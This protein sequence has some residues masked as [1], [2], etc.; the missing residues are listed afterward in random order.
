MNE[1]TNAF[2]EMGDHKYHIGHFKIWERTENYFTGS[3]KFRIDDDSC[4]DVELNTDGY[5]A[6][7]YVNGDACWYFP[8]IYF[9]KINLPKMEATLHGAIYCP[10]GLSPEE[11]VKYEAIRAIMISDVPY[12]MTPEV[13]HH[14]LMIFADWLKTKSIPQAKEYVDMALEVA[15][16]PVGE[17][18]ES[19]GDSDEGSDESEDDEE[20]DN[21][22]SDTSGSEESDES[23][24]DS[25]EE[26]KEEKMK[27]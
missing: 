23:S 4:P 10:L 24:A 17:D 13:W 20:E 15:K 11:E 9:T 21:E 16:I 25:M 19:S 5:S 1:N 18:E 7:L 2:L 26:K 27:K 8:W 12:S 3:V 14:L 6:R 22:E